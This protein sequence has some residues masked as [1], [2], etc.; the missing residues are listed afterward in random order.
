M[1]NEAYNEARVVSEQ[2]I[3]A[4]K[5]KNHDLNKVL[6]SQAKKSLQKAMNLKDS[7]PHQLDCYT[8]ASK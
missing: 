4:N 3:L 7:A 1:A 6:Y 5:F 2:R 8:S